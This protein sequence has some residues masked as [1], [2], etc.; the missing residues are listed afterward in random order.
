MGKLDIWKKKGLGPLIYTRY[1][2]YFK[3]DHIPKSKT[4]KCSQEYLCDLGLGN[5]CLDIT[6]MAQSIKEK[7]DKLA[8]LKCKT[9]ALQK[10]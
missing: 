7:C 8:S 9:L 10:M 4:V 5:N 1:Q 2:H 6:P 3:V